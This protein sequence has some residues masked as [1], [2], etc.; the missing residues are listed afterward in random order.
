M[1]IWGTLCF[2]CSSAFY[3]LGILKLRPNKRPQTPFQRM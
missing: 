1:K 2:L 3:V